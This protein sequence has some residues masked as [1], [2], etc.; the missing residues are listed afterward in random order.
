MSHNIKKDNP[1]YSLISTD[2]LKQNKHKY[3]NKGSSFEKINKNKECIHSLEN[4][5]KEDSKIHR[6]H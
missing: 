5:S 3:N 1:V 2:H 4:S 6:N